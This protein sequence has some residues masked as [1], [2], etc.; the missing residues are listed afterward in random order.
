MS[1]LN[2]N[3][4]T[5]T[6]YERFKNFL[7]QAC[8]ILLGN[9]KEYLIISRMTKL[10]RDENIASYDE[11]LTAVE[12]GNPH[13]MRDAVIDAMTT[14]ETSWFRDRSPFEALEKE[15]FSEM[16]NE[17]KRQCRIWSSACSSGQEPY[18]ISITLSEHLALF[19]MSS[20]TRTQIIATDISTS[21]LVEA[22]QAEYDEALL[23][24]GLSAERKQ[25]FF[26][27]VGDRWMVTDDIKRRVSF[28]EQNLLLSYDALGKFDI[29]FCRNVL[30]YFSPERKSDILNRMAR[31]LNP[32]GYL[33]L[34]ASETITGYSD[35]FEMIRGQQ[36]V[37]YR[38]KS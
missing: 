6:D 1:T 23:G 33:F 2:I 4:I 10:L 29:I 19:P 7:E 21:M 8:G 24:R 35:A 14:N 13:H 3:T 9:G 12:S 16:D 30:I 15:V 38:L 27:Q 36:G 37:Y 20:L 17:G 22:K 34:G 18:T 31:A 32:K 5:T 26:R 28:K 11:L 25:Q